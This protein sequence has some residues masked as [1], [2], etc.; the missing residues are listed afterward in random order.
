M[1]NIISLR[2]AYTSEGFPGGSS[3]KGPA[4]QSRRRKSWCLTVANCNG[5]K[6]H[7]AFRRVVWLRVGAPNMVVASIII[8]VTKKFLERDE[9]EVLGQE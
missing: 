2:Q 8:T 4:C 9:V 3:G 6:A 7:K 1:Y 5:K